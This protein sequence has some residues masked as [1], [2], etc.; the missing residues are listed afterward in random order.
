MKQQLKC[1][2]CGTTENVMD[3]DTWCGYGLCEPCWFEEADNK[4]SE[5]FD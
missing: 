2:K 1:K 5:Y 4:N 3:D